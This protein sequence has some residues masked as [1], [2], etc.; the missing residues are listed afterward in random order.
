[1]IKKIIQCLAFLCCLVAATVRAGATEPPIL[2][3]A[4]VLQTAEKFA[5]EKKWD[6]VQA[7]REAR[8]NKATREWAVRIQIKQSGG[9]MVIY[10]R[11]DTGTPRFVPGE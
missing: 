1:M 11:D 4:Q 5:H 2:E 8:F 6:L 9:P 3:K 10:V 7:P